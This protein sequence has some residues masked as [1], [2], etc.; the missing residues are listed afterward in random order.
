M[1]T[2]KQKLGSAEIQLVNNG[3][4]PLIKVLVPQ[5]TPLAAT[6]KLQPKISEFLKGL[7]GCLACNSGVPILFQEREDL[8]VLAR[9]DLDTLK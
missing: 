6:V 3:T 4:Q 7:K 5:G 2:K 9:V 1:A 8:Q